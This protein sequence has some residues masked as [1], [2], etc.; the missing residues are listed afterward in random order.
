MTVLTLYSCTSHSRTSGACE[1]AATL[2][3]GGALVLG[4]QEAAASCP[5]HFAERSVAAVVS[6]PIRVP[7]A[8]PESYAA[9]SVPAGLLAGHCFAV[10]VAGG[11][12]AESG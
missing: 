4:M 8:A 3:G 5:T 11:R 7:E 1:R 12:K 2:S 9:F 6:S 10:V